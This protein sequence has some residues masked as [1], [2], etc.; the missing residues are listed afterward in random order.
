M[1]RPRNT[2]PTFAHALAD[3]DDGAMWSP[4][5]ATARKARAVEIL[6]QMLVDEGPCLPESLCDYLA[7]E[8]VSRLIG[9]G[10]L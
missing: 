4:T 7:R 1:T 6:R 8:G 9:G 3:V 10:V 5:A 2:D